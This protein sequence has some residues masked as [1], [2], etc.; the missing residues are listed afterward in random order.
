MQ[1]MKCSVSRCPAAAS[2]R[3][4]VIG[5][6]AVGGPVATRQLLLHS[7]ET[8][9]AVPISPE[10]VKELQGA[11]QNLFVTFAEKA[12]ATRPKRHEMMEWTTNDER[13]SVEVFCNPNAHTTAFDAKLLI[14][15]AS[16]GGL[17]VTTEARL[18]AITSDVDDFM[19]S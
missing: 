19:K 6:A 10:K 1:A 16:E 11:I 18:S 5:R 12:K 15:V 9:I 2:R 3:P 13:V 4:S 17:K 7:G 8:T 14:T